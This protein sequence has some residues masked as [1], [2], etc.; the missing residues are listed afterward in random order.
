MKIVKKRMDQDLLPS[1]TIGRG[2][3]GQGL[4]DRLQAWNRSWT[5]KTDQA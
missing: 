5:E 3:R 1:H 4:S 2:G